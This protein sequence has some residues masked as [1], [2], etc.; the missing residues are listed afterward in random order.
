MNFALR[1]YRWLAHA[2][3]HEFKVIYGADVIQLG[4]DVVEDISKQHGVTG[5]FRL[6]ADIAIRV[7]IEYLAEMRRDLVYAVRTLSKSRG[8][9]AVG[10]ISLGLG[11]G[12]AAVSVSESL[13]LI[14]RDAPGAKDPDSLVMVSGVSYPYFE[15]YRDQKDLFSAGAAVDMAVPFNVSLGTGVKTERIFGQLVS[16]EFFSTLGVGA[17]RGRVFSPESDKP[18]SEPVVFVTDRFWRQHMDSDPNAVGRTIR[19]NGQTATIVGVGPKDFLGMMP[20][21]PGDIFVPTTAPASIAPELAGDVIHKGEARE[22]AALLRLAPGVKLQSAEAG[23]DTLT[24]HLD[25]ETLDPARNTKGRRV[26]LLPGGKVVPVPKPMIPMV[27]GLMLLLDGLIVG[28]ACMNLANMQLAR[29]TARRREV[30]IRLSV[31]ASRFRL[32]RQLLTESVL[33]AIGGGVA[34]ILIAY[35]AAHL[36]RTAKLPINV[37]VNLD[38][39][40][41]WRVIVIVFAISLVAG[42]GFGLAPALASTKTDLASTLKESSAGQLRGHRRFSMRNV[43]MVMQ[44]A[45]SLTLLLVAGFLIIGYTRMNNVEIAF[46]PSSMLLFS[47]DPV[48]DGY[49]T[50]KAAKLLDDLPGKLR[51]VPGVREAVLTEAAPFGPQAAVAALSAPPQ[52]GF[53]EQVVSGVAKNKIGANYFAS[54]SVSMLEGRE[55][56]MHDQR[57]DVTPATV[58]PVVINQTAAHA[59]FGNLD[60]LGRRISDSGRAYS[61]DPMDSM[62]LLPGARGSGKSYMVVG[63]VKDLSAPMSQS[64]VGQ[65]AATVPVVY[66]PLTRSDFAH[67]PGNG[68][69]VLVRTDRGVEAMEGVRR[70]LA[71][72]D[73]NLALFN[74]KTL[75][76]Q[77][78]E[79]GSWLRVSSLIYTGIGAFGLILAAIGLAGV[80]AYSV[81]RR[82]KELGI[83]IALGAR[84]SQVLGLVMREGGVLVI[85]GCVV[86]MAGG[87]AFSRALGAL[88]SMMGP[89][90]AAGAHDP[91][92][93]IGAPVLLAALAMLACYVPARRSTK[94]DPLVALREE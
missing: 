72:I 86:G 11:I 63:V 49:A 78:D 51:A 13:N 61:A 42:I 57:L 26:T 41:D 81:A 75:A 70:E 66:L 46:D 48:R 43:L 53:P 92:L 60:P 94:I 69:I 28:I 52:D 62:G 15:H 50:D 37:P 12:V 84:K 25:E 14:L 20:I 76:Q 32:I 56:D 8:F 36:L 21:I 55:F 79:T 5:L 38:I 80:T 83:R 6:V 64:A 24:R 27:F 19:V 44:V 29:A 58:L 93:L 30:A 59:F 1:M 2:F 71:G 3:P 67:P 16:P 31:G 73:P 35:W 18:G 65:A 74:V 91:R 7:P 33:L 22:F 47:L 90:F 23:L 54:L 9:A 77:V 40:P 68:M 17:A 39:T 88:S 10:I 87:F 89:S 4:E 45:G 82:R 85:I 34:G